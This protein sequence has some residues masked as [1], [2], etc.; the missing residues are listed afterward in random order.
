MNNQSH[1]EIISIA[2]VHHS[3][4]DLLNLI[5]LLATTIDLQNKQIK[6]LKR[7]VLNDHEHKEEETE[8]QVEG[9]EKEQEDDENESF[10][11]YKLLGAY[12]QRIVSQSNEIRTL[13][14]KARSKLLR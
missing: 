4:D 9:L 10:D 7:L 8:T 6:I 14:A 12:R 1:D 5:S 2:P 11:V 13:K 3:I